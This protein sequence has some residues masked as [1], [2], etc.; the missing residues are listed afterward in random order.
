MNVEPVV[1]L[2]FLKEAD[3]MHGEFG[4]DVKAEMLPG[5]GCQHTSAWCALDEAL[6]YKVGLDDVFDGVARLRQPGRDRLDADGPAAEIHCDH[7]KI[8]SVE[9]VKAE[10]VDFETR[11]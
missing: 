5:I 8:A 1:S 2:L 9:L 11:Q 10:R 7:G 3:L 6:L 4:R